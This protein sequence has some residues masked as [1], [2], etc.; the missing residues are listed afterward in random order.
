MMSTLARASEFT[1]WS[2]PTRTQQIILHFKSTSYSQKMT[3]EEATKDIM[4][5]KRVRGGHK[6]AFTRLTTR[7][8]DLLRASI[9][10]VEK[11]C[12]AEALL[13]SL[14][15]NIL[16]FYRWDTEIQQEIEDEAELETDT[17][18]STTFHVSSGIKIARLTALIDNYKR[19]TAARTNSSPRSSSSPS[20]TNSPKL[21]KLNYSVSVVHI[22]NGIRFEIFSTHQ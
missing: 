11:L 3:T 6:A 9:E 20:S 18:A 5:L 1:F 12:E 14:S 4:K 16:E 17:Q 2:T 10:D 7:V 15:R 8:D 19:R 21:P 22:Q 13:T